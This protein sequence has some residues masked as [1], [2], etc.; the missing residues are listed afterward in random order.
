MDT[1]AAHD[2]VQKCGV[3][4]AHEKFENCFRYS[5]AC[6]FT[7]VPVDTHTQEKPEG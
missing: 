1:Q 4:D 6:Q 7:E 5:W 3:N 2:L